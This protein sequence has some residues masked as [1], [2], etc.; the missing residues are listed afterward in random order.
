MTQSTID[1]VIAIVKKETG[2]DEITPETSL[3]QDIGVD[4]LDKIQIAMELEEEFNLSIPDDDL[5]DKGNDTVK[6]LADY[7]DRQLALTGAQQN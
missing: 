5:D 3:T 7:I 1:R 4:S 2:V 6:G